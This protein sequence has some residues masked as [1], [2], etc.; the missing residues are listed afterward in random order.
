VGSLCSACMQ[1]R[2]EVGRRCLPEACTSVFYPWV[3]TARGGGGG[4]L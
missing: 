2:R 3:C 4:G 1:Q